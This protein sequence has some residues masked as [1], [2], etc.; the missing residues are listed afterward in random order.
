MDHNKATAN[1][2]IGRVLEDLTKQNYSDYTIGQYRHCYNGL[3]R[4]MEKLGQ[5]H[6][7]AETGLDYIR[8]MSVQRSA[9]CKFYGTTM[10]TAAWSSKYGQ[11]AKGLNARRNS[12]KN[13]MRLLM[14]ARCVAI[15]LWEKRRFSALSESFSSF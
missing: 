7:T 15:R 5:E 11:G 2:V 1:E 6:Y 12:R 13:T 10:N 9:P 4:Y 3:R 8:R 14:N